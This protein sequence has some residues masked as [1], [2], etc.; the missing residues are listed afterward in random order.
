MSHCDLTMTFFGQSSMYS[1]KL[2]ESKLIEEIRLLL[3]YRTA[4]YST[5]NSNARLKRRL[6][7]SAP[8]VIHRCVYTRVS[9]S[10]AGNA[11]SA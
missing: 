11:C 8:G 5:C 7:C 9:V 4:P 10:A 2:A 6:R 3:L 1:D